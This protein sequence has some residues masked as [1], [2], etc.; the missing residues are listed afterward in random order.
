MPEKTSFAGKFQA[1]LNRGIAYMLISTLAFSIMNLVVKVISHIP[2]TELIL[3]RSLISFGLSYYTIRK[4]KINPFGNNKKSLILRG[5]FGTIA[6]TCYFYT[7]QNIPLASAVTLQHLSPIF[8]AFLAVFMLGEKLAP[9]QVVFF[10]LSFAGVALVKGFDERINL[11]FF[12]LGLS[13]AVFAGLAYNFVR[14]LAKTDH[15]IVVVFYFPLIAIP[16]MLVLSFFN[17]V[18]PTG[19]DWAYI[20]LMGICTQV[21]QLYM[22]KALHA[23]KANKVIILKYL[24]VIYALI[25]SVFLLGETYSFLALLGIILVLSGIVLNVS[26]KQKA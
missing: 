7:I 15:P 13:S 4:L 2:P 10:I 16:V 24:N 3:F 22:T 14:K 21:G 23:E 12:M 6:L 19:W 5:V 11:L 9:I 1:P 26:Y 25:F 20:I 18:T 8:T 17:W